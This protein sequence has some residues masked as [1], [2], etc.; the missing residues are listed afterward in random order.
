M[1][2]DE[3]AFFNQQLAVM[4]RD[5]IPL[6]GALR[7]LAT[8]MRGGAL[9]GELEKLGADLSQGTP[10]KQALAARQLP[11]FYKHMIEAG[12]AA[13][14]L[15]G[16]LILLGD[17][18]QRANLLWTRLKGLL[19]Y[20]VLVLVAAFQL[21]AF[22]TFLVLTLLAGL[23]ENWMF[24][25][26]PPGLVLGLWTPPIFL[27]FMVILTAV[28]LSVPGIR[29]RLRWRLPAFHDASLAG[30]A[31]AMSLMLRQGG[32]LGDSLKLAR[33]L[34]G[35]TR[36]GTELGEW[37][38]RL[39]DGRGKFVD[40]AQPGKAFPPLFVWLVAN[41]GEDLAGGFQ[42][43]A[44]IYGARAAHRVEL[45]LYAVLP[46]A[47]VVLGGMILG[48]IYPLAGMLS[49]ILNMMDGK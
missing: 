36:A 21:S 12:V 45:F 2:Y 47:V 16:M 18:Y 10:L 8:N 4:L 7:Q 32:N 24:Q 14:D 9:R 28:F 29:R 30:V 33:Q 48:Q 13:N 22:I 49:Q 44:E 15:P 23:E 1:N 42:R 35:G 43:A 27:G 17:H 11:D 3:F 6:E 46:C 34:E 39:A 25:R 20:P 5:G 31:G 41:S 40:L 19:V 37:G 38:R 26:I